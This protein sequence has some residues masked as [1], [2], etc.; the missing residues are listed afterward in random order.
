M[1]DLPKTTNPSDLRRGV[2]VVFLM[3]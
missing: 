3:L 1:T 2:I